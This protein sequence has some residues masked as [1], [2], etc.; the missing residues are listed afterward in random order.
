VLFYLDGNAFDAK[1]ERR[2]AYDERATLVA[3]LEGPLSGQLATAGSASCHVAPVHIMRANEHGSR[4]RTPEEEQRQLSPIGLQLC[5]GFVLISASELR[6][7]GVRARLT[8]RLLRP[9]IRL[10]ERG[11]WHPLQLGSIG[12]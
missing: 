4:R 11:V 5:I 1:A 3:R 12:R 2:S 7:S 6:M 10:S 8:L 9:D